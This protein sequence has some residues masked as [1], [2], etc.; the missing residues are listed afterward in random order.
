[1]IDKQHRLTRTPE[2]KAT[3]RR[4]TDIS[5][6]SLPS[7]SILLSGSHA[8]YLNT[9]SSSRGRSWIRHGNLQTGVYVCLW[10]VHSMGLCFTAQLFNYSRSPA[11]TFC[12]LAVFLLMQI[13]K[14]KYNGVWHLFSEWEWRNTLRCSIVFLFFKELEVNTSIVNWIAL[15][16]G[17]ESIIY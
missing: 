8:V 4:R 10:S 7:L 12:F 17:S 9:R 11:V 14:N 13:M 3:E 15:F 5:L 1:M 16:L 6:L 2:T